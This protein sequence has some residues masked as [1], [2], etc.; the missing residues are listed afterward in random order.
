MKAKAENE[1]R[2]RAVKRFVV[3]HFQSDGKGM[4]SCSQYGE[5]PNIRQA[6]EVGRALAASVPGATFATIEDR[7]DAYPSA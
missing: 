3:T 4:A 2:V 6:V 5:F 7:S 1:F